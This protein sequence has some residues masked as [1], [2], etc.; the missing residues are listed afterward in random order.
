[1]NFRSIVVTCAALFAL[2]AQAQ[3]GTPV[4]DECKQLEA[5][6]GTWTGKAKFNFTG[7]EVEGP[8]KV[9]NRMSLN[10]RYLEGHHEYEMPEMGKFFG[11]QMMT[12]DSAK[13]E[14][15]SYW[16]D[17]SESG[18]MEMRGKKEGDWFVLSGTYKAEGMEMEMRNKVK[19][20]G[21]SM[22]MVLEMKMGDDWM[23]MM[24]A[25]YK[26]S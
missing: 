20:S 9:T 24:T 1:M 13:G 21:T 4:P 6:V 17:S 18:A 12:Y 11:L 15:L 25:E 5:I 22:S 19:V 3:M 7:E 2:G 14:W 23:P 26:K 10:G 16:F 8:V